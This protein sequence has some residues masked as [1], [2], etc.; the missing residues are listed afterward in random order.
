MPALILAANKLV[1]TLVNPNVLLPLTI[2]VNGIV[3]RSM[4]NPL[5]PDEP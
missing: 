5:F 3:N 1:L 4:K 2:C